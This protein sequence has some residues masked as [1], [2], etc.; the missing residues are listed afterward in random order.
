MRRKEGNLETGERKEEYF[1]LCV[2]RKMWRA[3]TE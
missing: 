3:V 2:W 1:V